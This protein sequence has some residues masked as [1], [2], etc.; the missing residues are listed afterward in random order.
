MDDAAHVQLAKVLNEAEGLVAISN[1]ECALMDKLYPAP[2]WT[3]VYS[4]QKTIHSTKDVR[5]EVL[6]VN[7]DIE[8]LK[9]RINL[10]LFQNE[11]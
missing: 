11:E 1:Y 3:K 9:N 7:Y 4:P 10:S 8:S 6:W 2:Q 5:Q